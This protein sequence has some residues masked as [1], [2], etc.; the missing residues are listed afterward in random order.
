LITEELYL[1]VKK[2]V[3]ASEGRFVSISEVVRVAVW[4]SLNASAK[5][6]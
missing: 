2:H 3:D 6:T 5:E 1:R 4:E